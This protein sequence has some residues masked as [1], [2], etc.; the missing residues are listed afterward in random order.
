FSPMVFVKAGLVMLLLWK[1]QRKQSCIGQLPPGP[2]PY[3]LLGNVLQ[4]DH[5]ITHTISVPLINMY[6]FLSK[7]YGSVFTIWLAN[8]PVVIISGYQALKDTLIGLGEE[9]SGRA[10][11]PLLKNHFCLTGHCWKQMRRFTLMMLKN[12][13]MGHRSFEEQV[14]EE[15]E[16]K[17]KVLRKKK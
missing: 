11:Y 10:T 4:I 9:F 1:S 14:R 8:S 12:F 2:T 16:K 7:K 15:A 13:G 5:I 3:P 17:C 6:T